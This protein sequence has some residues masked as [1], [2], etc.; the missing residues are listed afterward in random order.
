MPW[1]TVGPTT[2]PMFYGTHSG[3]ARPAMHAHIERRG[4]GTRQAQLSPPNHS[5]IPGA[6]DGAGRYQKGS[7][8]VQMLRVS[9]VIWKR[10]RMQAVAELC[11]CR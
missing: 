10:L 5:R 2:H 3:S 8:W 6:P 4:N 1:E 9:L 11:G 7:K